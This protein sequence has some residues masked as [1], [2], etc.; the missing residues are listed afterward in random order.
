MVGFNHSGNKKKNK[1]IFTIGINK[2]N[3]KKLS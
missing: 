2:I 1:I 3:L